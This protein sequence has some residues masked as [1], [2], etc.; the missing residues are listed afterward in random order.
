MTS[1]AIS[2]ADV[3]Q[4]AFDLEELE[5]FSGSFGALD[6]AGVWPSERPATALVAEK[7]E[8]GMP[9]LT[10]ACALALETWYLPLQRCFMVI[11]QLQS[12]SCLSIQ[13]LY[14]SR[15]SS[16]CTADKTE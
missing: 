7:E 5:K 13:A 10:H 4:C 6:L 16:Y 15:K 12:T 8:R 9:A 3:V 2:E 14:T 11:I 1:S